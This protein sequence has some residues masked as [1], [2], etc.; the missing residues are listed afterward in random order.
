MGTPLWAD[1]HASFHAG[2]VSRLHPAGDR[3]GD[4]AVYRR[5]GQRALEGLAAVAAA[6]GSSIRAARIWGAAQRLREE[7][8]T[9]LSLA[10]RPRY[11]QCGAAACAA[12]ADDAAFD[13]AWQEGRA[14]TLKQA[15]ELA[16]E[17][18]RP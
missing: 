9:P 18:E 11:D 6:L 2:A 17:D 14:L 8:G 4:V 5:R 7:I 1:L 16:S 12:V 15:I 13:R 3:H 10:E